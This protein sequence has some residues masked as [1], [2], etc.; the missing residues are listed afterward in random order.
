[1]TVEDNAPGRSS[2]A[3]SIRR[4]AAAA[5]GLDHAAAGSPNGVVHIRAAIAFSTCEPPLGA[6]QL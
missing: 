6:G 1:M 3:G 4:E 5:T 2:T